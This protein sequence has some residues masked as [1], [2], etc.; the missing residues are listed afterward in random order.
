MSALKKLSMYLFALAALFGLLAAPLQ[1]AAAAPQYAVCQQWHTVKSGE[2]LS[3]IAVLYDTTWMRLAELNNLKDPN[4]L[5]AGN[6]LC[7]AATGTGSVSSGGT[8]GSGGVPTATPSSGSSGSSSNTLIYASSVIED[9]YVTVQGR[10]LL[11][12]ATY[13]VFM[14]SYKADLSRATLAGS[15]RTDS[16]GTYKITL[17]IPKRLVDVYKINLY[18]ESS[19]GSLV[20]SNWFYN[21]TADNSQIGGIGSPAPSFSFTI[22]AIKPAKS[23]TIKTKGLPANAVFEVRIGKYGTKGDGGIL[24]GS[25]YDDDGVVKATFDIP[26]ELADRSRLDIRVESDK[27]GAVYWMSFDND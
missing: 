25:V 12:N 9:R 23:I 17:R 20:A 27:V 13:R 21:A 4:K 18:L 10:Y 14:S 5:Y 8:S 11:A 24:V 1:P 19:R 26:A 7:V 6:R 16:K 22:E 2:T 3:K 15:V